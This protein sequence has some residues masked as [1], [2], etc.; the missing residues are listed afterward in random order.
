ME[1]SPYSE[2]RKVP[3]DYQGIK[4]SAF[5]V[6]INKENEYKEVGVVR[7]NYLLI[8]NEEVKNIV[9]DIARSTGYNFEIAKTHFDGKKF[10]YNLFAQDNTKEMEVG[11]TI[12][13]GLSAWNSYDGSV[14]FNLKFIAYRL[15]C[16]NGMMSNS[17]FSSFKFKHDLNSKDWNHELNRAKEMFSASEPRLDLFVNS[18]N[19]LA[20]TVDVSNLETIRTQYIP[21]VPSSIY[22]K[23]LDEYWTDEYK[24]TAW[25]FLN[26]STKVLWHKD[27]STVADFKH[28]QYIVDGMFRYGRD[29]NRTY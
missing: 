7:N 29:N 12:G 26:A 21:D 23:I 16:L 3:L 13:L 9:D 22:G 2:I 19:R 14:A 15:E 8:P 28:N 18:C 6:Q 11:D 24:D 20:T 25:D 10:V 4:S 27:K 17:V 1:Y 5:S